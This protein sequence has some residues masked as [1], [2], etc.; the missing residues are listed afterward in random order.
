[1]Q[2]RDRDFEDFE[3]TTK[4]FM[5]MYDHENLYTSLSTPAVKMVYEKLFYVAQAATIGL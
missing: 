1:M 3:V 5:K 4:E 2:Q